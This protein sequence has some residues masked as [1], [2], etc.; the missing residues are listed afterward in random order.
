MELRYRPL[1]GWPGQMTM[2]RKRAP[3]KASY[4]STLQ[5]LDRELR[6]LGAERVVVQAALPER[7]IRLD[8]LP[9]ND[10]RP[11]HPGIIISFESRHGPLSY[12]C[13]TYDRLEDNI[14]AIALSLEYLRAVNRYGVTK[15]GEQY[16][17]WTALP[18]PPR[19]MTREEALEVLS[20]YADLEVPQAERSRDAYRRA[21]MATHPDRG[22]NVDAFNRV[23]QAKE[24]LG[25]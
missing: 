24:V 21:A 15:H 23:Q 2:R 22:G 19:K 17:G 7:D 12:P 9:R 8:G 6:A 18:A 14:R 16:R 20:P 11:A 3:F 13:D 5:L 10:A 1:V 25:L 4:S